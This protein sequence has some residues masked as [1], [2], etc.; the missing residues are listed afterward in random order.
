MII[1]LRVYD[2]GFIFLRTKM[3]KKKIEFFGNPNFKK[4]INQFLTQVLLNE[5]EY[6]NE[7]AKCANDY[8]MAYYGSKGM[9]KESVDINSKTGDYL[10]I[11][12][13]TRDNIAQFSYE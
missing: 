6:L 9:I 4:E 1:S 7:I 12:K 10:N 2:K 3:K 5:K 8:T 13:A 11:P